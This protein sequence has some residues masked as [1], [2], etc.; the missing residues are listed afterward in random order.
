[1]AVIKSGNHS[2]N[3]RKSGLDNLLAIGKK[4]KKWK[5]ATAFK[6]ILKE[7]MDEDF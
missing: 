1:M 3:L 5:S 6:L 4:N 2:S 7:T